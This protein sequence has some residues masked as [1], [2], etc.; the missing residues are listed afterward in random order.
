MGVTMPK[1]YQKVTAKSEMEPDK[2]GYWK[3]KK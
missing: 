2:G 3:V 1:V